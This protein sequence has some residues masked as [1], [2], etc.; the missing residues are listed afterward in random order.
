MVQGSERDGNHLLPSNADR[1]SVAFLSVSVYT[2][3]DP[4]DT[5]VPRVGMCSVKRIEEKKFRF[6][7]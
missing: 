3:C 5:D 4:R 2:N 7:Y 6:F 1:M